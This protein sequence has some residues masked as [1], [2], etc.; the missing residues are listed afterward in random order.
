[1]LKNPLL[2]ACVVIHLSSFSLGASDVE[3]LKAAHALVFE[4]VKS[5]D[6]PLIAASV[7]P[8]AMGF[9]LTSHFPAKLTVRR[10][11]QEIAPYIMS[12]LSG[13]ARTE[14]S[15][16]YRVAGTV[17]I[18][19]AT[20]QLMPRGQE[21]KKPGYRRTTLIYG[22]SGDQW[23]LVSWHSSDAPLKRDK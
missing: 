18:V 7:H 20:I 14:M 2:T 13:F 21:K 17:G 11:I 22:Y 6:I 3:G 5:A 4:A 15:T 9:F 8:R 12:D 23:K 19:C 1:M 10:G 16:E